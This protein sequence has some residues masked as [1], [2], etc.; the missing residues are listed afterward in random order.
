MASAG[1]ADR[2]DCSNE[3]HERCLRKRVPFTCKMP[4][5]SEYT[6]RSAEG[7]EAALDHVASQQE[8]RNDI[9]AMLHM[10]V[11]PM[12]LFSPL[13]VEA[14]HLFNASQ[15]RPLP[16]PIYK[17]PAVYARAAE[18][19]QSEIAE[20]NKEKQRA[21]ERKSG[22]SGKIRSHSQRARSGVR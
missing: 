3:S 20:I 10:D 9:A 15:S 8:H 12:G 1:N 4:T 17:E 22:E 6:I 13:V 16:W 19:I 5:R 7:L 11:C 21:V 14:M 18:V 2:F